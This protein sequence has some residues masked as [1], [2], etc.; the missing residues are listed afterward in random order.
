MPGSAPYQV[1]VT[2]PTLFCCDVSVA[3][4][5]GNS[6]T[7]VKGAPTAGQY[8]VAAGVYT[9]AAADAGKSLTFS[10]AAA[11]IPADIVGC[12]VQ[13]VN[14][15]WASRGRD[16][17]LVQRDTPGVGTERFWFGGAPGQDGPFPPD[18]AAILDPY[19]FMVVA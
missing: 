4:L 11:D 16:P 6:F 10:F 2:D 12:M 1:S 13:A 14:S 17:S 18:I 3:D 7:R 9:F 5:T 19:R 15:R 8:A